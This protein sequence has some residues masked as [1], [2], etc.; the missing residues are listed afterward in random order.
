MSAKEAFIEA[1]NALPP[2]VASF[3]TTPIPSV[4]P[5]SSPADVEE[6]LIANGRLSSHINSILMAFGGMTPVELLLR[7]GQHNNVL[8]AALLAALEYRSG[9]FSIVAPADGET[10]YGVF[11]DWEVANVRGAVERVTIRWG[12]DE[13]DMASATAGTYT[14]E[15]P[16]PL[17]QHTAEVHVTYQG[18]TT[19]SQAVT[20]SVLECQTVPEDGET[21]S[22]GTEFKLLGG[23]QLDRVRVTYRQ[24]MIEQTLEAVYDATE[25]V[26]KA[27]LVAPNTPGHFWALWEYAGAVFTFE[28]I[29]TGQIL[30]EPLPT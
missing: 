10:Y 12:A 21:V 7:I 26:W 4:E 24:E 27:G 17:G 9:G 5:I 13:V 29:V 6:A 19:E 1:L 15:F 16:I 2:G 11:M 8:Q 18:G 25:N 3:L 22:P 28:K 23:E 14:A 30:Y 20:F